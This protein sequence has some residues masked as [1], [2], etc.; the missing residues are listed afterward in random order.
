MNEDLEEYLSNLS[1]E[2]ILDYYET[3]IRH[4]H[5][6]PCECHCFDDY[7]IKASPGEIKQYIIGQI[8]KGVH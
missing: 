8:R 4:N 5:Y 2:E 1:F 3:S 6:C 7:K